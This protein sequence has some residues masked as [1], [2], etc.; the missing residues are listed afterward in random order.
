MALRIRW[1]G[2]PDRSSGPGRSWSYPRAM[3][4]P[5]SP[6]NSNR[7]RPLP[8]V[9]PHVSTAA[10]SPRRSIDR[11]LPLPDGQARCGQPR[12]RGSCAGEQP[13]GRWP[14]TQHSA[15]SSQSLDTALAS[16]RITGLWK[17]KPGCDILAGNGP[18]QRASHARE[19]RP[20][21]REAVHKSRGS[22]HHLPH[23]A[24]GRK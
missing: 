4:A 11:L 8:R 1:A 16:P 5:G 6:R 18:E 2:L 22:R 13:S 21:A 19:R 9:Q 12:G 14:P 3:P 20:R 10:S 15:M 7:A 17:S 24:A 23:P